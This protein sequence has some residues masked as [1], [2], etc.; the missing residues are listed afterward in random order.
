MSVVLLD[1]V[2]PRASE[3]WERLAE[4]Y[5]SLFNSPPWM[6]VLGDAFGLDI[7]ATIVHA[8]QQTHGLALATIDDPAGHR[9]ATLP[10]C[11]YFDP[12]STDR[13]MWGAFRSITESGTP[14]SIRLRTNLV[15]APPPLQLAA[16]DAWHGVDLRR[17]TSQIHAELGASTR[18]NLKKASQSDLVP[19]IESTAQAIE[20]FRQ[21]HADTR[22]SK[23]SMLAQPPEF[24]SALQTHFGANNLAVVGA[25]QD[26]QLVAAILLLRWGTTA[27]YK[28]NASS[29]AGRVSRGNDLCMWNAIEFAKHEWGAEL[30]DL[31][32][33]DPAQLGL[34][35]YKEKYATRSAA[36][37]SYNNRE[38]REQRS[39]STFGSVLNQVTGLVLRDEVP[40]H[41]RDEASSMLYRYFC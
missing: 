23:Y 39:H 38:F 27:Y 17:S 33:S 28:F 1:Q 32:L 12:L 21:L 2:D 37:Q 13:F 5:G 6:R 24:F 3:V 31:G 15:A 36:I 8:D 19:I 11:D 20:D 25:R 34:V 40:N 14:Y 4:E 29:H 9:L 26:G 7:S 18:R 16:T 22:R 41:V 35:R 30:L 10:F